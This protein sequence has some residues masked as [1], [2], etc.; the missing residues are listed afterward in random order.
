MTRRWQLRFLLA[1]AAW[2]VWSPSRALVLDWE[3]IT[4][5]PGTLTNS[6]DIDPNNAGDD[7]R[8]TITGDVSFFN[9]GYPTVN[10]AFTGGL[11]DGENANLDLWLNSWSSDTQKIT[12]TVEFLYNLG[13]SNVNFTLFDVDRG[14][15]R[16]NNYTFVDEISSISARYGT[17]AAVAATITDGTANNV[18]G[19]GLGQTIRAV[20]Q[21]E[22]DDNSS[23]NATISFGG[24]TITTFTFTYG[25]Y[26]PG[27]ANNPSQQGIGLHNIYF[28]EAPEPASIVALALAVV[29]LAFARGRVRRR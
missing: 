7:I 27:T 28:A 9:S 23:G 29:A 19:T 3:T 16:P 10:D 15:G 11:P 5:S 25:N 14:T 24:N 13:V 17:N 1:L 18:Y 21:A 6:Y 20:A 26:A 2:L 8:I 22:P 4:W 12:I